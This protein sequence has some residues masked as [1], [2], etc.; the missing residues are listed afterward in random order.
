MR[1]RRQRQS[2]RRNLPDGIA[3]DRSWCRSGPYCFDDLAPCT[4]VTR[5]FVLRLRGAVP[6]ALPDPAAR[7]LFRRLLPR[8]RG[9]LLRL[10]RLQGLS[11][12]A[13]ALSHQDRQRH[14][15]HRRSIASMRMSCHGTQPGLS[16]SRRLA[17]R[18]SAQP[19]SRARRAE[20]RGEGPEEVWRDRRHRRALA[21]MSRRIEFGASARLR[22][23]PGFAMKPAT[24]LRKTGETF[25]IAKASPP[26]PSGSRLLAAAACAPSPK[27]SRRRRRSFMPT[28][29][30][31]PRSDAPARS[32][33]N[34]ARD[35]WRHPR[36]TLG[37][38]GVEP[39]DTVVEIWPGGGWYT[40]ILAPFC[41]EQ[42]HLLCGRQRAAA[43]RRPG[44]PGRRT[45]RPTARSATPPSRPVSR[46]RPS[47]GF[48]TA[49]PT[50]SSPSA[51]STIG[52]CRTTPFAEE[53]FRQ[54]F[55]MLKPG[56]TLGVAEHRLPESADPA[57]EKTSGYIKVSTVRRLA[58]AAGFRLVGVERDQ[59]QSRRHQGPSQRRLVA[60]AEPSRQ[61]GGPR[62]LSRH[63]RERPD[64]PEV[65]EAGG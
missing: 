24:D 16:T 23:P 11:N 6:R 51:T 63:R 22:A 33:A 28:R 18:W 12:R 31:P 50:S 21:R 44:A 20:D 60:S 62:A 45:R 54:I 17:R 57:R 46:R 29:R 8:R 43:R 35:P 39:T 41:R 55:A 40:E 15:H 19:A 38:F 26:P 59:R 58:E 49:P 14:A 47:R 2:G 48:R 10:Q 5:Q 27:S 64:D 30:S 13:R 65:R 9:G 4:C 56:G 7:H 52:S 36:E 32:E 53:A 42:R 1:R 61:G 34:R 25:M 3:V 37:F